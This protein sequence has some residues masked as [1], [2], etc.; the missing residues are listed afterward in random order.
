MNKGLFKRIAITLTVPLVILLVGLLFTYQVIPIQWVSS[1]EI[2][3]SFRPMEDPLPVPAR[4]VPVQGAAFLP[5]A[6]NPENPA[7]ADPASIAR[8]KD[9][10]ITSCYVCHGGGDGN[11]PVAEK[12]TRKPADLT[13]VNVQELSDGE[14]FMVITSGVK[15][16]DNQISMPDL[17]ENLAANDRWDVVNYVRSLQQ[18]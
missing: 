8:G 3:P 2:Q 15:F 10:Y 13:G 12:L 6:G 1:M 9:F 16:S 7:P 11:G 4:S 18:P 14:I 5:G 17:R